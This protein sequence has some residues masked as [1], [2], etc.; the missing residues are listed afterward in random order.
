M[1]RHAQHCAVSRNG[2]PRVAQGLSFSNA[3]DDWCSIKVLASPLPDDVGRRVVF[4]ASDHKDASATVA[5]LT[6][7][8]GFAAIEVGKIAEGG[9]LI[10]ARA[11]LVS[12]AAI[13]I[14]RSC[15]ERHATSRRLAPAGFGAGAH[16][17][18]DWGYDQDRT[19]QL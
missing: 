9:R 1:Q 15:V 10:Q 13:M 6:E 14:A 2:D 8:L 11:P 16:F 17:S 19:L 4:V 5:A 12:I 7:S 3:W 18:G